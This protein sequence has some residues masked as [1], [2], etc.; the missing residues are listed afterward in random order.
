LIDDDEEAAEE[1]KVS[2]AFLL[3]DESVEVGVLD[4]E[5]EDD[6]GVDIEDVEID[7]AEEDGG[8]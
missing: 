8:I 3:V 7:G 6:A 4:V 5:G 2:E 1:D